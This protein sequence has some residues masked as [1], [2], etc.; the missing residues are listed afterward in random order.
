MRQYSYLVFINKSRRFIMLLVFLLSLAIFANISTPFGQAANQYVENLAAGT[1]YETKLYV[2]ESGQPG[3]VVMITGGMHGNE[4]AGYKAAARTTNFNITRG[5]L[6]VIPQI[7][8]RA[9]ARHVRYIK[10]EGN[11]NRDYPTARGENPDTVLA[12]D[13]WYVLQKYN[14]DWLMDMHE[15]YDYKKNPKTDSIG[16]SLV[17]YPNPGTHDI[18]SNIV[19]TLNQDISSSYRKF[20]LGGSPPVNGSLARAAGQYLGIHSF[21]LETSDNPSLSVRV[22]F[23]LKA[24]RTLLKQLEML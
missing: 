10:G 3:P 18:V 19:K 22:N 6:L 9:A 24:A 5:T 15:G 21:I 20:T 17:Y 16:Q 12:C 2:I 1:K 23:H 8:T 11:F 13:I 7:N 14:V 4:P